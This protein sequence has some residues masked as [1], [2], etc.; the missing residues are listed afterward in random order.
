MVGAFPELS[1]A[2]QAVVPGAQQLA[3]HRVA[4]LV[5]Q[6]P[7]RRREPP[8]A[9]RR[10]P[11]RPLGIA[12]RRRLDDPLEIG[13]QAGIAR[14][15]RLAPAAHPAHPLAQ[16]HAIVEIVQPAADR[17][18]RNP[19]D[20]R[21]RGQPAPARGPHLARRKQTTLTLIKMRRQLRVPLSDPTFIE[22]ESTYGSRIGIATTKS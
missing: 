20:P 21:H 14:R 17:A 8:Q 11:Q 15:H 18:A 13:N 7:Q 4:D 6:F 19:G 16:H 5:A 9:L 3:D 12:P 10:P 22:H 1:V 2:L